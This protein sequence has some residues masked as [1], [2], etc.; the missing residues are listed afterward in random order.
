MPKTLKFPKGFLWGASTAAYQV[1]GGIENCDWSKDFPAGRAC[2]QYNRYEEDFDLIKKLNQNV[3]RFSI[4]WSRIEPEQGRFDQKEI[5]HYRKVLLALK[6]RGIKTMVTLHHFANPLWLA[7]IGGWSNSKVVFYFSRFSER[8]FNEYQD[9]VDFWITINEPQAYVGEAYIMGR[10]PPKKKNP[11]LA[12]RVFKNQTLAHKKVYE[13]FHKI[14]GQK[15]VRIG[16]AKNNSFFEPANPRSIL[17]KFS[18]K[19]AR[20]F[21]NSYFLKKI[22]NHLDF[23]GLNY[24]FRNKVKFPWLVR[25]ENKVV[26]DMGWEIY[27]E[28]IY[29]AVKELKDYQKPIYITENG[30]A[31]AKDEKRKDF[32]KGHLFWLHN[33][34]KEGLDIRGYLHW[35]LIDNFEWDK[36]FWPRF[37]L[38]EMDY[39]TMGRKPRPSAFYYANICKENALIINNH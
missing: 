5:E 16:I 34:I 25:N 7:R 32:I 6:S 18:V 39:K 23:I 17:D 24:Y 31:D 3:H 19:V 28:G 33:A 35:S 12:L 10:R 37:G 22:K 26:S 15:I 21:W 29:H 30:L 11:F 38:I 20:Y 8:V 13:I 36:G 14:S 1:E 9:L 4:E 27:P 2:D